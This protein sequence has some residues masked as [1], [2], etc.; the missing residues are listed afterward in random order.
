MR[1]IRLEIVAPLP[2]AGQYAPVVRINQKLLLT[3]G[4][5]DR[6]DE[7]LKKAMAA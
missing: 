7:N 3:T 6:I 5:L 2:V 4:F 1:K